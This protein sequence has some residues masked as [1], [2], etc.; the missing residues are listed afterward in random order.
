MFD[1]MVTKDIVNKDVLT[2]L[3]LAI[4]ASPERTAAEAATHPQH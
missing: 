4:E 2:A 3:Q 1:T